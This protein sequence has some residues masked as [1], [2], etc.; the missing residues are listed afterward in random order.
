[1]MLHSPTTI[2]PSVVVR[3]PPAVEEGAEP[4]NIIT[5]NNEMVVGDKSPRRIVE[6]PALRVDI[7]LKNSA[8]DLSVREP[9][10]GLFQKV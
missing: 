2:T 8:I 7:E 3:I 1:M 10:I 9:Y 4:M 5:E 6:N